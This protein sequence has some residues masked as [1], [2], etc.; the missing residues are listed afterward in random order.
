MKLA[1]LK[2]RLTLAEF[3]E[4]TRMKSSATS[5]KITVT[6]MGKS[7]IIEAGTEHQI[8][9]LIKLLPLAQDVTEYLG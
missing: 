8:K 5:S 1:I 4:L 7:L 3:E 6:D 2:T 9:E